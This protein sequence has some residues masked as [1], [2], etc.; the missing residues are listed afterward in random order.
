VILHTD[1]E[2]SYRDALLI[3]FAYVGIV[4]ILAVLLDVFV[5]VGRPPVGDLCCQYHGL[6]P[7][8]TRSDHLLMMVPV[9]MWTV[10]A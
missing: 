2:Q 8:L 5:R 4:S 9:R 6:L 7:T 10:Y 3:R 1:H